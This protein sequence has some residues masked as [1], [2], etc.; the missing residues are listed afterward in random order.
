VQTGGYLTPSRRRPDQQRTHYRQIL[1]R[2]IRAQAQLSHSWLEIASWVGGLLGGLSVT[3]AASVWLREQW[4]LL[5]RFPYGLGLHLDVAIGDPGHVVFVVNQR[6]APVNVELWGVLPRTFTPR[7]LLPRVVPADRVDSRALLSVS[8]V[9]F[10]HGL[11]TIEPG[12]YVHLRT[13]RQTTDLLTPE[14][15]RKFQS[16]IMHES[17]D[18]MAEIERVMS[19]FV[20]EDPAYWKWPKGTPLVPFIQIPGVGYIFGAPTSGPFSQTGGYPGYPCSSCGHDWAQHE[21]SSARTWRRIRLRVDGCT[22]CACTK[23][24]GSQPGYLPR[25]R[26]R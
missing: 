18:D 4:I 23:F 5:R 16:P 26:Y 14:Q 21:H 8:D 17:E 13:V 24:S 7:G 20:A 25:D 12:E 22:D 3:A 11:L 15:Q 10:T 6:Q 19:H 9:N 1:Q 2:W